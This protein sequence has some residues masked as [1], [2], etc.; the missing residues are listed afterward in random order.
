MV[1]VDQT[2]V[3]TM[4][5]IEKQGPAS[6]SPPFKTHWNGAAINLLAEERTIS[7]FT[8]TN[9]PLATDKR[10]ADLFIEQ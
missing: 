1:T 4:T 3:N 5:E 6:L 2:I 7:M 10:C 8:L 9:S